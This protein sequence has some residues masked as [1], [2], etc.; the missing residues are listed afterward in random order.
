MDMLSIGR[1]LWKH[2]IITALVV[3]LTGSGAVYLAV[4]APATY[5]SSTTMLLVAPPNPPTVAEIE[6]DPSLGEVNADNPYT[7]SY[8]P[9]IVI[10]VVATVVNEENDEALT[11]AGADDY[12]VTQTARYGFGSPI[13]EV[14][15]T[16]DTPE[17]AEE[18]AALVADAFRF[19]LERLQ[20]AEDVDP[21]YLIETRTV[22][23]ARTGEQRI[24]GTLRALLAVAGLG[25]VVLFIAVSS[26][27]ALETLRAEKRARRLQEDLAGEPAERRPGP[28]AETEHTRD[29]VSG[30]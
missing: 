5:E 1:M 30:S 27:E 18:T 25:L 13:V 8:D 11:A 28:D 16:S 2:K 12:L 3:L 23:P 24:S 10:N 9:A 17:G 14:Q 22:Q 19:E 29:A 21:E 15:A 26:A 6:A 7:R 20:Q 4:V